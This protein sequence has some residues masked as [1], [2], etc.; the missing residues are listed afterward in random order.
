MIHAP[1]PGSVRAPSPLEQDT[2]GND[3]RTRVIQV[4][5]QFMQTLGPHGWTI[6]QLRRGARRPVSFAVRRQDGRPAWETDLELAVK[7]YRPAA[8]QDVAVARQQFES[9]ARLH[10]KLN[11]QG[12]PRLADWGPGPG[13]SMRAAG[14]PGD[15]PWCRA[16]PSTLACNRPAACPRR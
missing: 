1:R 11:D 2:G 14:R 9:L 12:G 7:L 10:E 4:L 8:W 3:L 6:D 16:G 13:V 5:R 15:D